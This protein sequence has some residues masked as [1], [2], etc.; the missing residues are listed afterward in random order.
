MSDLVWAATIAAT[1]PTLAVVVAFFAQRSKIKEVHTLVND[2]LE[3][4]MATIEQLK[5]ELRGR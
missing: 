4:A 5:D 3:K 1:P 2:R